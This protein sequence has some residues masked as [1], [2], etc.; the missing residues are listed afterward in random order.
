MAASSGKSCG[1]VSIIIGIVIV[2][3]AL[4]GITCGG[5]HYKLRCTPER[6]V[7]V[8]KKK[9]PIIPPKPKSTTTSPTYTHQLNDESIHL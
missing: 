1:I 7:E 8:D 4:F 5:S 6:G 2:W 9:P 3:A